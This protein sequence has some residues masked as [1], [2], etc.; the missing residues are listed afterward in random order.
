MLVQIWPQPSVFSAH[1]S[2]SMWKK[3]VESIKETLMCKACMCT[4]VL[5]DGL[6]CF[7]VKDKIISFT[8]IWKIARISKFGLPK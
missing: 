1:S 4:C 7:K 3:H 2:I 5:V 8:S 6:I